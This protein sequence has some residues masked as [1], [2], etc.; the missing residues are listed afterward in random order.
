[1]KLA[2]GMLLVLMVSSAYGEVLTWTDSR[3]TAHYTNSLYEVPARY[4]A[5]VK[6]LNLGPEPNAPGAPPVQQPQQAT[7]PAV[8]VTV[9]PQKSRPSPVK[10]RPHRRGSAEGDD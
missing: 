10:G 2:A 7:Q 3:G 4:R 1:M 6:V 9:E 5:K 8:P